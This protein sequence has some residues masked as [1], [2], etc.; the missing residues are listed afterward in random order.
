[1]RSGHLYCERGD[2]EL[3]IFLQQSLLERFPTQEEVAPPRPTTVPDFSWFCPACGS[4]LEKEQMK[5]PRGH[6]SILNLRHTMVE[7]HPH[8][9][10]P[11]G[12]M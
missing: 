9:G 5:C 1:M 2:M 3:S 8:K 7:L 11:Y 6:A 12:W 4:I 10:G